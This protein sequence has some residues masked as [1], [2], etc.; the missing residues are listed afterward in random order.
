MQATL[1]EYQFHQRLCARDDPIAFAELAEWLY[2]GLLQD[3]RTRAGYRA[4]PMLVEE[5]VGQALLDYHEQPD[6]YDPARL[7]LQKY[8][9]MS[10]YRDLQNASAKEQRVQAHQVSLFDP[11]F[12]F[13]ELIEDIE[14]LKSI[15]EQLAV[16]ELWAVIDETFPDPVD[17]G[18]VELIVNHEHASEPY[19]RL[20]QPGDLPRD[21]Q[22]RLA[23]LA[24]YRVARRLR[25]HL[26]QWLA[27]AHTRAHTGGDAL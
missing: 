27:R 1:Q 18:I 21:E 6:R 5:A 14:G 11:A 25:R 24:Q 20:L 12:Q 9:V 15:D 8:L 3:V 7:S 19:I 26:A 23:K 13:D 22:V 10:A 16:D 2:S 17:R 4:D